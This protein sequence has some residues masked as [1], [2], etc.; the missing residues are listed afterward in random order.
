MLHTRFLGNSSSCSLMMPG[1]LEAL[2]PFR[3]SICEELPTHRSS[4]KCCPKIERMLCIRHYISKNFINILA[5]SAF[6]R[7]LEGVRMGR[8][9]LIGEWR[10]STPR[11]KLATAPVN[12]RRADIPASE[13]IISLISARP[14]GEEWLL[15]IREL[16]V[17]DIDLMLEAIVSR[18]ELVFTEIG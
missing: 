8:I 6:R 2:Q 11:V 5:F 15:G 4:G 18:D 1:L 13:V 10:E 16:A 12:I 7:S 9:R 3:Q 17:A 14:V